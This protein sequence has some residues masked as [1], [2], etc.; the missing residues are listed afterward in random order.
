MEDRIASAMELKGMKQSQ[1]ADQLDVSQSTV[2]DYVRGQKRPRRKRVERLAEVLGV[3][4]QWLVFGEGEGPSPDLAGQRSEYAERAGW[5]FRKAPRDGGRDYG[6]ANL[7]SF[8]PDIDTLVRETGQNA[9]DQ[10]L[11]DVPGYRSDKPVR[12]DYNLITLEDSYLEDFLSALK[13]SE[14]R[15]HYEA[16]AEEGAGQKALRR[17]RIGFRSFKNRIEKEGR[18]RLLRIDDYNTTGLTGDEYGEGHF[19]AL[20]RNNLDSSKTSG[21][22]RG[23]TYGLGKASLWLCSE[24]SLVLF[25]SNPYRPKRR[26]Q[27]IFGRSELTWHEVR[28]DGDAEAFAG[29]GWFGQLTEDGSQE[30]AESYWGN[31]ALAKDLQLHRK[32]AGPGTS[33]SIV[34]F[35]DPGGRGET[36]AEIADG[37]EKKVSQHFWPAIERDGLRVHVE[38]QE[39]DETVRHSRVEPEN[40]VPHFV[41]AH[42]AYMEGKS[43][44]DLESERDGGPPVADKEVQ[45]EIPARKEPYRDDKDLPDEDEAVTHNARLLV[46]KENRSDGKNKVVFFRGAG[47]I[48]KEYGPLSLGIGSR[49][50]TAVVMCGEAAGDSPSDRAAEVFLRT[51]EPPSHD[52]WTLTQDAKDL[53]KRGAGKNLERFVKE[54]VRSEIRDLVRPLPEKHEDGPDELKRLMRLNISS[55]S[56]PRPTLRPPK[57][58]VTDEGRWELTVTVRSVPQSGWKVE[59]SVRLVGESGGGG[60]I[61]IRSLTAQKNC[62]VDDCAL[63]IDQG[64]RTAEFQIL[65]DVP[66]VPAY[67]SGVAVNLD[68]IEKLK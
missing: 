6:N 36:M 64:A 32:G 30:L 61:E 15:H 58:T 40:E 55:G 42:S 57:G 34:G 19:A 47:M 12:L 10:A 45:L 53:Y 25:N 50:F 20:C 2:S 5:Q 13:W 21:T 7:F 16:I 66:E 35:E 28:Q 62:E 26:R 1:I 14:L 41:D 49:P 38:V 31:D 68:R 33:I 46:R 60:K 43:G 8:S 22:N 63:I 59:P 52:D 54:E 3:E 44:N 4:P 65:T 27:R 29:P 9:K 11:S 67:E 48:V 23:G 18:L 24:I 51:A 56:P 37:I 17:L 39:N